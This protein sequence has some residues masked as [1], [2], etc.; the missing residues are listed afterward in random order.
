MTPRDSRKAASLTRTCFCLLL[1]LGAEGVSPL[2]SFFDARTVKGKLRHIKIFKSFCAEKL[3]Q[4]GQCQ[5][6]SGWKCST[7][8]SLGRD[9]HREKA[10]TK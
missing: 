2:V 1:L 5:T 4:I 3:I 6:K 8:W 10:E 9:L 7:N